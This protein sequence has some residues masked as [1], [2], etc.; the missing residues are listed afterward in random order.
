[1]ADPLRSNPAR[2][3]VIGARRGR[4]P[5]KLP[6]HY[7]RAGLPL[8]A[9]IHNQQGI[10]VSQ[11]RPS[12]GL[13]ADLVYNAPRPQLAHGLRRGWTAWHVL[14]INGLRSFVP[15]IGALSLLAVGLLGLRASCRWPATASGAPRLSGICSNPR[16]SRCQFPHRIQPGHRSPVFDCQNR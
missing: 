5:M 10:V 8:S 12:S 3:P 1:M 6:A 9:P 15:C 2:H 4:Q 14:S 16:R 7:T 13:V 11:C